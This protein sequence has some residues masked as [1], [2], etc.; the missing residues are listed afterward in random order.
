[1]FNLIKVREQF[2]KE[3]TGC[4]LC[5][6]NCPIIPKTELKG[7]DPQ[8]IMAEVLDLF[9]NKKVGD[10]ARK[11]IYSCLLLLYLHGILPPRSYSGPWLCRRQGDPP[12][13][14]GPRAQRRFLDSTSC[15]SV[16][17]NGLAVL[18]GTSPGGELVNNRNK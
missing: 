12:G 8:K 7:V 3:C 10:L 9:E 14:W 2:G 4:G 6:E 17:P 18:S 13:N 16:D 5:L 11:R 1:M 15:R